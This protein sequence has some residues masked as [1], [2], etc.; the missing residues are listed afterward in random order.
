M[1]TGAPRSGFTATSLDAIAAEASVSRVILYRHFE[2][3]AD[4]YRAVLD[5]AQAQLSAAVG[6]GDY[7]PESVDAPIEAAVEDPAG[8]RLLFQH[9]ARER[10]AVPWPGAAQAHRVTY[11]VGQGGRA[12][13][14]AG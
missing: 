1:S 9:A 2:S 4:L 11:P 5:H 12:A 3:K 6:A 13:G 8:F 10:T 7:T 14:R